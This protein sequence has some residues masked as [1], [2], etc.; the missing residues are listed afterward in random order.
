M[1]MKLGLSATKAIAKESRTPTK[2]SQL[3]T[4]L[5]QALS[6]HSNSS[7][8]FSPSELR[9]LRA[10]SSKRHTRPPFIQKTPPPEPKPKPLP[11]LEKVHA[12]YDK[13]IRGEFTKK[14]TLALF[15]DINAILAHHIENTH[16]VDPN[17]SQGLC[18]GR[19][20][21]SSEV[22]KALN[23]QE[24]YVSER[25]V[26]HCGMEADGYAH[27]ET[28][29]VLVINLPKDQYF[30]TNNEYGSMQIPQSTHSA[31]V[32]KVIPTFSRKVCESAWSTV[33]D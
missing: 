20:H 21:I 26:T 8:Y 13:Y 18:H 24:V 11:S 19:R 4:V 33:Y 29:G 32:C 16:E 30:D 5:S 17:N 7:P 1:H 23:G 15:E 25:F 28:G 22:K 2:T 9:A 14:E 6:S 10:Q 27:L 3:K 12:A 31:P